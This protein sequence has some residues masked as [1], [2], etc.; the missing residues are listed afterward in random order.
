[1]AYQNECC[2]EVEILNNIIEGANEVK[3]M[4]LDGCATEYFEKKLSMLFWKNGFHL[5]IV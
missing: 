3:Q 1:M 5:F 4:F 2:A